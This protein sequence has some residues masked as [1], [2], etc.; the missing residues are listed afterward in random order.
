[1]AIPHRILGKTG[2]DVSVLGFGGSEIGYQS[3]AQK[4]VDTI[5]NRALDAGINAI[6]TA[7]CYEQSETLIGRALAKRRAE[8][9]LMT[10]CGHAS[11]LFRSDWDPTM[12]EKSIERSLKRLRTDCVDVMQFH[13]CGAATLRDNRVLEVLVRA[14]EAGKCRFIGYSGDADDAVVAVE[15]GVFDTLQIS[16]NLADQQAIDLVLPKATERKMGVI[17]KRPIANAVW[18]NGAAPSEWYTR[19]YWDRLKRLDYDFLRGDIASSVAIAIGFTLAT[20]G[21][22]TAIVGTT[23]PEN[24]ERNVAMVSS[25]T[26]AK[27]DYDRIRARWTEASRPDWVGQR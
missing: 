15:T 9:V 11:G 8:I 27:A 26:L 1:M 3:V 10:K 22:H 5:L 25:G 6:D 4:T 2:L 24:V 16:V 20:P 14:R 13:S 17:A 19:P 7:E 12:I 23:R 21:V 18:R